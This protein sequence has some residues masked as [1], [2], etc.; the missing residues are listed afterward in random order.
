MRVSPLFLATLLLAACS[1]DPAS[2]PPSTDAGAEVGGDVQLLPDTGTDTGMD[3]GGDLGAVDAGGLG[4]VATDQ[5]LRLDV[6]PE[7]S[8]PD[9]GGEDRAEA[10][11]PL[12][13]QPPEDRPQLPTDTGADTG[14]DAGVDV[15]ADRPTCTE[16][17]TECSNATTMRVCRGGAW[18]EVACGR[19]TSG[20]QEVCTAS[21]RA[22][23]LASPPCTAD[24]QCG[25][26]YV[27]CVAAVCLWR[28]TVACTDDLACEDV[29]GAGAPFRCVAATFHGQAVRVCQEMS[30][31]PR[32][33]VLDR[34]CPTGRRCEVA[35]GLCVR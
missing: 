9:A 4:D 1:S 15:V 13:A 27:A 6:G 25:Y 16:G 18:T 35:T 11:G 3:T 14:G 17:A 8:A 28:G 31:A 10:G 33:C 29:Y 24:A 7:A 34:Q 12:D 32:P 20:T 19:S 26:G 21:S 5:E 22:C 23:G 30:Y 2:P